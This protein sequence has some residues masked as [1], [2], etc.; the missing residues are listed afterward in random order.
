[1][2]VLSDTVYDVEIRPVNDDTSL[3]V[4]KHAADVAMFLCCPKNSWN[5]SGW[6]V[7]QDRGSLHFGIKLNNADMENIKAVALRYGFDLTSEG[8]RRVLTAV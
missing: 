3:M 5:E 8:A 2:H 4:I 6:T 7:V 1:M